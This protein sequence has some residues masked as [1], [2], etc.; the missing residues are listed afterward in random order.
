MTLFWQD[1]RG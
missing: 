1:Y